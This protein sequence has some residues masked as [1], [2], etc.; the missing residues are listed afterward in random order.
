MGA[1]Q[2]SC[3]GPESNNIDTHQAMSET[4]QVSDLDAFV[5]AILFFVE[6]L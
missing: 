6:T 1:C 3:C 2:T 4:T 5:L